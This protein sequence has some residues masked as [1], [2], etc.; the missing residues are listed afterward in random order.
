MLRYSVHRTD[1]LPL[2]FVKQLLDVIN[3]PDGRLAM[4][5]QAKNAVD[6]LDKFVGLAKELA[7]LPALVLPQYRP[8]AVDLYKICQNI[9][10]AN[11]NVSR[12]FFRF[13][14][15]DFQTTNARSEFLK[16]VQEYKTMKSGP[17]FHQLKFSCHE[18][19]GIYHQNISSKI[20]LW[21]TNQQQIDTAQGIFEK[22]TSV[23]GSMVLFISEDVIGRLDMFINEVELAVDNG[24]L[25]T[26]E[27][28][29]LEFKR[30]SQ[31][32]VQLLEWFS[33]K[34]SGLVIDFATIAQIPITI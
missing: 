34:L 6:I 23:D 26:A 3:P 30:R 22:L 7:K 31:E 5:S 24:D 27:K 28:Q 20:G 15:F 10:K 9:L 12:W 29:R 14:Y 4:I 32:I 13:L 25:N 2:I 18:I 11:E 17:E 16:A 21:F 1:G 19:Q 8:C 33:G